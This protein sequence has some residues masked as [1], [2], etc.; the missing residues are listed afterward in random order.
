MKKLKTRTI[1]CI[2]MLIGGLTVLVFSLIVHYPS[3]EV[4][5]ILLITLLVC[6]FLGKLIKVA[7]DKI[8]ITEAKETDDSKETFMKPVEVEIQKETDP[9]VMEEQ[10]ET[11]S[12]ESIGEELMEESGIVEPE[13]EENQG[14]EE[15]DSVQDQVE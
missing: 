5:R 10:L 3:R 13:W 9:F 4:L 12:D 7:V 14:Y 2:V 11:E 6:Y 8:E 15:D 1:P